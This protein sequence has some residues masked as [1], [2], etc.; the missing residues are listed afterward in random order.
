MEYQRLRNLLIKL[1]HDPARAGG[2]SLLVLKEF[3][4]ILK[5]SGSSDGLVFIRKQC[6]FVLFILG[7]MRYNYRGRYVQPGSSYFMFS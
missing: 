4:R 6:A 3:N 5:M 1:S 2:I 7:Y